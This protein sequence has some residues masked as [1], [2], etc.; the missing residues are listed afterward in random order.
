MRDEATMHR[1]TPGLSGLHLSYSAGPDSTKRREE[2]GKKNHT[3][4]SG[5]SVSATI[6][7]FN[8]RSGLRNTSCS[9]LLALKKSLTALIRMNH[10]TIINR[11]ANQSL[12]MPLEEELDEP[13]AAW[14][15]WVMAAFAAA[16]ALSAI[17][18]GSKSWLLGSCGGAN[19]GLSEPF[20]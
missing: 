11:Y 20:G 1:Q 3:T 7:T 2:K 12:L 13:D 4:V 5:A 17:L 10:P 18:A 6:G 14:E 19:A 9:C 15:A 8:P 16:A